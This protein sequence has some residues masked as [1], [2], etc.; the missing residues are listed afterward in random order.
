MRSS[1]TH[2]WTQDKNPVIKHEWKVE[3]NHKEE[4][5][6]RSQK[7]PL[8]QQTTHGSSE[9]CERLMSGQ[10]IFDGK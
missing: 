7:G 10:R 1:K 6:D 5:R 3:E 2:D 9:L 4:H 8:H